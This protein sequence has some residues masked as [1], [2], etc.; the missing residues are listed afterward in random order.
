MLN[1]EKIGPTHAQ[2]GGRERERAM[3]P[4]K[5]VFHCYDVQTSAKVDH[6]TV[7]EAEGVN[8]A[9][10]TVQ[11]DNSPNWCSFDWVVR[12]CLK[13]QGMIIMSVSVWSETGTRN[14]L[15]LEML[16]KVQRKTSRQFQSRMRTF[17]CPILIN[18][19]MRHAVQLH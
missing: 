2:I 15:D 6:Q 18:Y 11:I 3:P 1:Y 17:L 5:T 9:L 8:T 7:L 16:V 13:L 4:C 10:K 19:K 14:N 12:N